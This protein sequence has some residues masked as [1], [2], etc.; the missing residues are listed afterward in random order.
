MKDA[1]NTHCYHFSE[2]LVENTIAAFNSSK[3]KVLYNA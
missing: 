1:I 3:M 2:D